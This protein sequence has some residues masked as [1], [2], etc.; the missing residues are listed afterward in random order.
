MVKDFNT[1]LRLHPLFQM[2]I[3]SPLELPETVMVI[4]TLYKPNISTTHFLTPPT[5]NTTW[6]LFLKQQ[7]AWIKDLIWNTFYDNIID[8]MIVTIQ[9]APSLLAVS[10]GSQQE[11]II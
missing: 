9:S 11:N 10:D 4:S 8:A 2:H 3:L 1:V 7:D 5:T 6:T